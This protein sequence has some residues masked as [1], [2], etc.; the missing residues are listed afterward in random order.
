M[1]RGYWMKE[2]SSVVVRMA[3]YL[4]LAL[5]RDRMPLKTDFG[6][7]NVFDGSFFF[8]TMPCGM[9]WRNETALDQPS[10]RG[11]HRYCKLAALRGKRIFKHAHIVLIEC[12]FHLH[13]TAINQFRCQMMA[14]A[15]SFAT[16]QTL[17]DHSGQLIR[18]Q[19]PVTTRR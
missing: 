7:S 1:A 18:K 17:G 13:V 5:K 19:V 14:V 15:E 9:P 6:G 11:A 4:A 12:R 16:D 3:H 8:N 10:Q 2:L